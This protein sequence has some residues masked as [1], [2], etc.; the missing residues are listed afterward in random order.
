IPLDKNDKDG[1]MSWD[2]TA[3]FV[4]IAGHRPYY[5]LTSGTIKVN[6][7]GSNT[8]IDKGG[9][10]FYLVEERPVLEVQDTINKM[11]MHQPK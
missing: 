2:E 6:D 3:V 11:M 9:S 5:K 4:A 10:H 1:R 8:W 7:D